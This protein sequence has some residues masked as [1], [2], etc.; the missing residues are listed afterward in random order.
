[1]ISALSYSPTGHVVFQRGV[2]AGEIWAIGFD[3]ESLTAVGEPFMVDPNGDMPTVS[4]VTAQRV[5]DSVRLVLLQRRDGAW[6]L[7]LS[8]S[9]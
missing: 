9:L 7:C 8:S 5:A 4:S 2:F 1:M 3:A 6:L